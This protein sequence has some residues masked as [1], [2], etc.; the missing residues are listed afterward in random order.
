MAIIIAEVEI[1]KIVAQFWRARYGVKEKSGIEIVASKRGEQ[2]NNVIIRH[3]T[4]TKPHYRP[5][6]CADSETIYVRLNHNKISDIRT[7][8]YLTIEGSRL[9]NNE[10]RSVMNDIFRNFMYAY[11]HSAYTNGFEVMQQSAIIAFAALYEIEITGRVYETLKKNWNRSEEKKNLY[12]EDYDQIRQSA[13]SNHR[14]VISLRK[15]LKLS[16]LSSRS[17][18]LSLF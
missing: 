4:N 1:E 9:I 12:K 8:R 5:G 11:L 14:T 3:L 16:D 18:Q 7:Y 2:F 15:H 13:V 10:L 17:K 6:N